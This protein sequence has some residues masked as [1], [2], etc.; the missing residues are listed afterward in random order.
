MNNEQY[1]NSDTMV[2]YPREIHPSVKL[3]KNVTIGINCILEEGVVVGD[4]CFIGHHVLVRPDT[5]IGNGVGIRAF[6]LVDPDVKIGDGC[7]IYPYSTIS[8][9]TVLGK[10]VYYGAYVVTANSSAPGVI[11]PPVIEDNVIIYASCKISP[12]VT[13]GRGAIIGMGSII[14]KDV[15]PMQMWYGE[16]SS[17]K[18]D[19]TKKD[20]NIEEDQPWPSVMLEYLEELE[21]N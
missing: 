10:N 14:T 9:K 17:Y 3:G 13:I 19:V 8:G 1:F 15:P 4:N 18:R 6:C 7:Q 16:A 2:E 5:I 12:G 20:F 11:I 21:E